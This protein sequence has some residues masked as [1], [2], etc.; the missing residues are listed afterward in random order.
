M[1]LPEESSDSFLAYL[2]RPDWFKAQLKG[3]FDKNRKE[4]RGIIFLMKEENSTVGC[5]YCEIQTTHLTYGEHKPV[6][7]WIQAE[8]EIIFRELL[9]EV[10]SYILKQ[11]GKSLRGPINLPKT[12]GGYGVQT[13]N[14]DLPFLEGLA[15]NEPQYFV[16]LQNAGYHVDAEYVTLHVTTPI[17]VSPP[18]NIQ[19]ESPTLAE[20]FGNKT[21]LNEV[22][23]FIQ[24]NFAGKLPD[25]SLPSRTFEIFER[26][27]TLKDHNRFYV[28]ARDTV[29][30]QIAGLILEIPN[31]MEIWQGKPITMTNIDTVIIGKPYR[32][33][34]LFNV[35]YTYVYNRTEA[36]GVHWHEGGMVW[37][38]NIPGMKTFSHISESYREYSVFQKEL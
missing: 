6:F 23:R 24:E 38:Q 4:S 10:E 7:G 1:I 36:I 33:L 32:T 13:T 22:V 21:L 11:G 27:A 17:I 12:F 3:S 26:M 16:W 9:H 37:K 30:N 31:F 34:G 14:F 15:S 5:I 28:L 29:T 20:I 35:M 19:L 8:S 18:A 2:N 25:T